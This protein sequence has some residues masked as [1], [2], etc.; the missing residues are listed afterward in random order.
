[1]EARSKALDDK[2]AAEAELDAEELRLAAEGGDDDEFEGM[3]DM[4]DDEDEG[5][6]GAA[7][8]E[9]VLPSVQ[10]R[11]EEK[12]N[13]GPELHVVQ[14]RMRECVRVLGKWKKLG[15]KSGRYALTNIDNGLT[16]MDRAHVDRARSTLTS[17]CRTSP[18]IMVITI[19]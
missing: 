13:G 12:K 18:V 19:S 8:E 2:A 11:E 17:W 9:F 7:G 16:L 3:D 15:E 5:E 10:E 1:M 4:D 6:P 14:R